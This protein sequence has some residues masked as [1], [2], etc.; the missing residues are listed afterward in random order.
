MKPNWSKEFSP[1]QR[2]LEEI[3]RR[4]VVIG[5]G[6]LSEESVTRRIA[7]DIGWKHAFDAW[8]TRALIVSIAYLDWAA[9]FLVGFMA[10]Y[11]V[12]ALR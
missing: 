8:A 10:G 12:S 3:E 1:R 11:I 9:V 6:K 7:K 4:N 5:E 2:S